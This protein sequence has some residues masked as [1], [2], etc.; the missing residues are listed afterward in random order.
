M[1]WWV[2]RFKKETRNRL[3]FPE[4]LFQQE[5]CQNCSCKKG[6]HDDVP[7]GERLAGTAGVVSG[8]GKSLSQRVNEGCV[9][10]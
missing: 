4:G 2:G 8:L 7:K 1:G 6:K 10:C 5:G 3:V 9:D